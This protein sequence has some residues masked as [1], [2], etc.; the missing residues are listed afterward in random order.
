M[1]TV[2]E[3]N[4]VERRY[5]ALIEAI[6]AHLVWVADPSGAMLQDLPRFRA[7][8]SQ[9]WDEFRGRG[10]T[11][12]IHPDDLAVV[13]QDWASAG[14]HHC[15]FE[16]EFRLR[17]AGGEYRW[18]AACGVPV[19]EDGRLSEW[20]GTFTDIHARRVR[21]EG[22]RFLADANELFASTLDEQAVLARLTASAVPALADWCSIALSSDEEGAQPIEATPPEIIRDVSDEMLTWFVDDATSL[23]SL[24]AMGVVHCIM[25]VPISVHGVTFG[26]FR[27]M[28]SRPD[29][30]YG[31]EEL[32]LACEFAHRAA[33]AIDKARLYAQATNANRAKDIFLATLSHEMK[34]PLTAILGWT[35]MLRDDGPCSDLFSEA[36]EAVEQSARVQERLIEDILDVSRVI[37]GKLHMEKKPVDLR[38]VIASAVEVVTPSAA[39]HGVR[40]HIHDQPGL[41]VLGDEM[42]LHQVIWNLLTNAVKFTPTGGFIEIDVSRSMKEA[43]VTVRDSG[44]GIHADFLPHMFD[45]FHQ[46]SLAD[47]AQHHGLGLGLAIVRQLVIAHGGAVEARS[48]GEGKGAEFII[49]LPLMAD[50]ES[51][52]DMTQQSDRKL[53]V[54]N[55]PVPS[56]N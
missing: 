2:I 13:E 51:D 27:L 43:S 44:R 32:Q 15:M 54:T 45:Q 28:A 53:T 6:P 16:S 35:R 22:A 48:D 18:F 36:L 46:A 49:T 40:L 30:H 42:R 3:D 10:W 38:N 39:Q 34:T 17:T 23:D 21:A 37:T 50:I 26:T 4:I 52:K 5:R 1:S 11:D 9:S 31:D 19:I 14:E 47:R 55:S 24:R 29:R 7:I 20:T 25:A 41:V 33:I 8:T 12:T 56:S